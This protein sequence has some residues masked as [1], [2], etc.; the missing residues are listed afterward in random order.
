MLQVLY[1]VKKFFR[2]DNSGSCAVGAR[3]PLEPGQC[4]HYLGGAL[5]P[6]QALTRQDNKNGG[7]K[8]AAFAMNILIAISR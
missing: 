3:R 7:R 8:V 4:S 6:L 1:K 5:P 2:V